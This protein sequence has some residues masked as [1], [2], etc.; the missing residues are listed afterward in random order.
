MKNTHNLYLF[1][2]IGHYICSS[3]YQ[4]VDKCPFCSIMKHPLMLKNKSIKIDIPVDDLTE[5][6]IS[7]LISD[8]ESN[9][10]KSDEEISEKKLN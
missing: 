5:E 8:Y 1:D 3:C 9:S 6:A 2:C 10:E 7:D 4:K